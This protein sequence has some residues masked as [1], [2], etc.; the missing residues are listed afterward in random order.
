[1]QMLIAQGQAALCSWAFSYPEPVKSSPL[2]RRGH[3]GQTMERR[4]PRTETLYLSGPTCQRHMLLG[5]QQQQAKEPLLFIPCGLHRPPA[6]IHQS[7]SHCAPP[8]SLTPGLTVGTQCSARMCGA[9]YW[10]NTAKERGTQVQ[11]ALEWGAQAQAWLDFTGPLNPC[12]E[13]FGGEKDVC[14]RNTQ[15]VLGEK[16][17]TT[18]NQNLHSGSCFRVPTKK[19][20]WSSVSQSVNQS[21]PPPQWL[22]SA[23]THCGSG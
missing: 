14:L 20:V 19:A 8:H 3:L 22:R 1:M 4:V 21:S 13:I 23:L 18:H 6:H 2:Q 17:T 10:P 15:E 11:T 12:V 5:Q 7:F 9:D 16:K